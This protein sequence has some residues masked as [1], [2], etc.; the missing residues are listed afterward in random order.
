VGTGLSY[1][2]EGKFEDGGS[3]RRAPHR[4][5]RLTIILNSVGR[6]RIVLVV[7]DEWLVRMEIADAFERAG[8]IVIEAGSGEEAIALLAEAAPIGLLVTDVRLP[9]PMTGWDVAEN[10]RARLPGLPV[11]YASAN[12]PIAA[13]QVSGSLF[14]EKPSRMPELMAAGE[15]L[16]LA[17]D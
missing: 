9:G 7:E 17:G 5:L 8:W 4:T 1:G 2:V 14:F 6:Q 13:R 11:L 16:W 10:Y 3:T 12:P 15:R